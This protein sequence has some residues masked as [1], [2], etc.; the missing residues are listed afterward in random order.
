M[1]TAAPVYIE[2][3]GATKARIFTPPLP[4]HCDEKGELRPEHTWGP[5]C[6]EFLTAVLGWQLLPWQVWLYYHAL[7]KGR[8]GTGFR[9][10]IVTVLVARQNGK[11]KWLK[12]LGLW[13]LFMD[14]YGRAK[15]GWPGARLVLIAAQNLD[16]AEGMLKE[17]VD[18]V[19]DNPMLLPELVNHRV[20]NGKHRMILTNRRNWRA[21]TAS[22]KGGRSL[23]VDLAMLDELREHTTNDAWNAIVPTTTVRP[24]SQVMCASNA[25]DLRSVVLRSLKES[26]TRRIQTGQTGETRNALFEWSVPMEVDPRNPAYWYLANPAMGMLND[27]SIEDLKGFL[28]AMEYKNMPGFQTEHL[29]QWVDALEPGII[30]AEHW[31]E[32]MDP[33]SRRAPNAPLWAAV[34]VN[35]PRTRSYIA[36]AAR[37]VDGNVHIELAAAQAGTDWVIPWFQARKGKFRGVAIQKTGAPA[38]GLAEEMELAGIPIVAWGPGLEV[39]AGCAAF[40]DKICQHVIFHRPALVLDRAAASAVARSVGDAWVFDRRN[41]PVDA[42]P[43]VACC[44]AAWLEAKPMEPQPDIHVWDEEEIARWEREA[45]EELT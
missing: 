35:Y 21:A 2:K 6:V 9:F 37:R 12:G 16:Y 5:D 13:R 8:D 30:L 36:I 10:L 40:F 23:S 15:P 42:A 44:A 31:Q 39:Q 34:D 26:C 28:E 33:T 32:T 43:V 45:E 27:F 17:I 1:T 29:C 18:E 4:E 24:Y 7:E 22:R 3:I 19:R 38:S 20:T 41:S 11:S 14:K 25:G